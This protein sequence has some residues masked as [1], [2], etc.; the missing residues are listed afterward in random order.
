MESRRIRIAA[1]ALA[2][3]MTA[4]GAPL[5]GRRFADEQQFVAA[6]AEWVII[7]RFDPQWPARIL[8]VDEGQHAIAFRHDGTP[9][10]YNGFA[11][12][13]MRAV[14]LEHEGGRGVIVLRS[15]ERA[16]EPLPA[17]PR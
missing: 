17:A 6:T 13:A 12:Y 2:G 4:C 7:G 10:E 9:R 16:A 3:T 15:R 11:G 1:L 5:E 8:Q 14:H